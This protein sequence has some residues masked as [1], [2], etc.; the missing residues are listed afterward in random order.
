MDYPNYLN[1][2]DAALYL[3]AAAAAKHV[4]ARIARVLD[5]TSFRPDLLGPDDAIVAQGGGNWGGLYPTHHALRL[6]LLRH[7]KGRPLLQLPQSIN[8]R[9]EK[10]RDELRRAVAQHGAVTLLVRDQPSFDLARADY[11]CRVELVPDTAVLLGHLARSAPHRAVSLQTRTDQEAGGDGAQVAASLSTRPW[12]WL[13][14]DPRSASRR[15]LAAS[16][17]LNRAQ[18]KVPGRAGR[19]PAVAAAAVLARASLAR[20]RGLLSA[21][22]HVITDRLHGHVLS[23]LYGI[24][25]V[26][27]NDR[28]GKISGLRDTWTATDPL[29]EFAATWSDVESAYRRLQERFPQ[30]R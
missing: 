7:S 4:G 9:D 13:E 25:H 14:A 23:T 12:D 10:H 8:Y 22:E 21:G 1:C 26:V 28:H 17:F 29:H 15:A 18:R 6:E 16:E 19:L 30:R 5:R 3:G 24:P 27:V 11:D 20:A 2:G